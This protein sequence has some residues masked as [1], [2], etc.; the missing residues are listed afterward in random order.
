MCACSISRIKM[1]SAT[2][3][4]GFILCTFIQLLPRRI[5][6]QYVNIVSDDMQQNNGW[7]ASSPNDVDYSYSSNNCPQQFSSLC[8]K[9]ANSDTL[10]PYIVQSFDIT[11]YYDIRVRF[12]LST[13]DLETGDLC[14]VYYAYDSIDN[15]QFLNSYTGGNNQ[16]T[17]YYDQSFELPLSESSDIVWIWFQVLS[18]PG[19]DT[20]GYDKCY[21]SKFYLD[22]VAGSTAPT[23]SSNPTT[24]PTKQPSLSP[25]M[26]PTKHPT[27]NPTSSPTIFPSNLPTVT[28]SR[29]PTPRPTGPSLLSCG[30]QATGDYNDQI[31]QFDVRLPYAADLTFDASSSSFTIQSLT[32][33]FGVTPIGADAD[34]D[35]ILTISNALAAHYIF[36]LR[37]SNGVY[38][39]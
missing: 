37:A 3:F 36:A 38:G 6:S 19:G 17:D 12:D 5:N 28:P 26:Y 31:L 25:T 18:I 32:A 16:G 2:I 1:R 14:E 22:G 24:S 13:M 39:T 9:I 10:T 15:K 8:I 11:E 23:K 30:Q 34:Y 29:A 7:T 33:V 4:I 21:I 35:G 20:M 27:S